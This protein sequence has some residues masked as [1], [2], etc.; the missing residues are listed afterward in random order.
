LD[1]DLHVAERGNVS[2]RATRNVLIHTA[3]RLFAERGIGA[4]SLREIGVAAGQRN[5]AVTQYHFGTR[6]DLIDAIYVYR[7]ER[8]NQRRLELLESLERE[9]LTGD[10][11]AVLTAVLTPHAESIA[12]RDDHFVEFLARVLTDEARI[13]II[14]GD[15]VGAV[16]A[17]L[18]GYRRLRA[19]ARRCVANVSDARFEQRYDRVFSW[20]IHS[21]AEFSRSAGAS[22]T[23]QEVKRLLGDLVTMLANALRAPVRTRN[24]RA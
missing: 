11:E 7:S 17:N 21:L 10:L 15:E 1:G 24:S 3:E 4:V 5:K 6:Q 9:R 22:P 14:G 18:D 23:K 12:D 20:A 13:S 2:G 16:E 8:I 19:L